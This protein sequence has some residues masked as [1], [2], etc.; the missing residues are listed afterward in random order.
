MD[1]KQETVLDAGSA[2]STP[3]WRRG[4]CSGRSRF[5]E[6]RLLL[7]LLEGGG[8][9]VDENVRDREER[10]WEMNLSTSDSIGM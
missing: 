3:I 6:R 4:A 10:E 9:V 2:V 7:R 1:L 5:E 8:S